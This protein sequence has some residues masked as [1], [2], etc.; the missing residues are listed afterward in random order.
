MPGIDGFELARRL[1]AALETRHAM[2]IAMTGYGQPADRL[3]GREVGF[4]HYLVKP[5]E[6]E[7]LLDLLRSRTTSPGA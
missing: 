4:D 3:A 1:R 2:L 5:V 6:V 7:R